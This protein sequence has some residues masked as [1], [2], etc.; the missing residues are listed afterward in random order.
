MGRGPFLAGRQFGRLG[1]QQ[2]DVKGPEVHGVEDAVAVPIRTDIG[3][4]T[5]VR[6]SLNRD[7]VKGCRCGA[8]VP[9]G[10]KCSSCLEQQAVVV[11]QGE[12]DLDLGL[13][14]GAP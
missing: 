2:G 11:E 13:F 3:G 12:V 5:R 7:A 4:Q 1:L 9:S 14:N 6:N 8:T 10:V